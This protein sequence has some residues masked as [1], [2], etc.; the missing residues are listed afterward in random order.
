MKTQSDL[1][2]FMEKQGLLELPEPIWVAD[3]FM[4]TINGNIIR[5]I[6]PTLAIPTLNKYFRD[7][8]FFKLGKNNQKLKA[9][10]SCESAGNGSGTMSYLSFHDTQEEALKFYLD[11]K[12]NYIKIYEKNI[13]EHKNV[14]NSLKKELELDK[15]D[16][17]VFFFKIKILKIYF[18]F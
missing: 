4:N 11:K 2:K 7:L 17:K 18:C 16:L 15:K 1:V 10:I 12:E 5:D 3:F 14:L 9:F 8:K 6:K 13:N